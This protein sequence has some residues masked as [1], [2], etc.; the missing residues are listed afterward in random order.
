MWKAVNDAIFGGKGILYKEQIDLSGKTFTAMGTLN[1]NAHNS[2]STMLTTIGIV[3]AKPEEWQPQIKKHVEH[4]QKYVE[5][6]NHIEGLFRDGR[7]LTD[8][9]QAIINLHRSVEEWQEIAREQAKNPVPPVKLVRAA[10]L[11]KGAKW[12]YVVVDQPPTG[13]FRF[14]VHINEK[15]YF[16]LENMVVVRTGTEADMLAAFNFDLQSI[17][18]EGWKLEDGTAV[19][20]S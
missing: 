17:Q 6:L 13:E 14:R 4:W 1:Q 7:K 12:R 18:E 11:S 20:A 9:K 3:R 8:I 10:F 5:Y 19:G 2:F 15:R 16:D